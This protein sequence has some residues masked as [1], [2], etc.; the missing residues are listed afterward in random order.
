MSGLLKLV[1]PRCGFYDLELVVLMA[2]FF[3]LKIED[4][5]A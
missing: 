5:G 3:E 1:S 2:L 4:E